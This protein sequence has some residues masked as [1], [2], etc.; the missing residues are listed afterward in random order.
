MLSLKEVARYD[1]QMRI[2]GWGEEG[3]IKLKKSKVVVA[4]V[5]GLGSP[6]ALYLAAAG[7]GKIKLVD[8]EKVELSN[9]NRQILHWEEDVGKY[10]VDSAA[11]KLRRFNRKVE[12]VLDQSRISRE[13]AP[14]LVKGFDA[15]VD[16]LDNFEAR[17]YLNE[18]CVK[19]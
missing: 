10:K 13:N 12:I 9:L 4:G 3:Q 17:F 19:E 7:I 15:A 11:E 5:G 2:E 6:V 18:A 14:K 8:N 1:R 16:A